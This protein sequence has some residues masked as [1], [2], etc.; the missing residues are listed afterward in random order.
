MKLKLK[1]VRE[2]KFMTQRELSEKSGVAQSTI[3]RLEQGGDA[4]FKTIKSLASAL[5]VEPGELAIL[6]A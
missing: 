5:D 4:T 6:P 3:V 1:E 2:S